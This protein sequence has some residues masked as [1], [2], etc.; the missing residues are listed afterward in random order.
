MILPN[1]LQSPDSIV[2]PRAS[3]S[4]TN[5]LV[6][7]NA[8][9]SIDQTVDDFEIVDLPVLGLTNQV[10]QMLRDISAVSKNLTFNLILLATVHFC[11]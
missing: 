8:I 11:D 3:H 10:G 2:S 6:L 4:P 5:Y 9:C 7:C 1:P